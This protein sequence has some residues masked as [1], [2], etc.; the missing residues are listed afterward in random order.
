MRKRIAIMAAG[1]QLFFASATLAQDLNGEPVSPGREWFRCPANHKGPQRYY[2]AK[3]QNFA[4][5]GTARIQCRF[6]LDGYPSECI[7]LTEPAPN[8][9]FGSTA[10]Q[11]GCMFRMQNIQ[12][13][14]S[15][16]LPIIS[17]PIKFS[18]RR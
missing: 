11:M 8:L 3:A 4:I 7:W 9:G 13:L 14:P 17:V 16:E 1:I 18:L 10:E 12:Y 2:P 15:G 5:E 6:Q